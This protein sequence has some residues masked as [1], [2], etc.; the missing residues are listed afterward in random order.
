MVSIFSREYFKANKA[1]KRELHKLKDKIHKVKSKQVKDMILNN[2]KDQLST[3]LMMIIL[4][5]KNLKKSI[6]KFLL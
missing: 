1:M 6:Q 2:S 5:F 3:L 4:K